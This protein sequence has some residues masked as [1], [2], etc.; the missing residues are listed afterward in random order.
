MLDIKVIRENPDWAKEKLA[1]RGIKPEEID[2]LIS[3]DQKRRVA[4]KS[5]RQSVT[6]FLSK[7]RKQ[8]ATRTTQARQLLTCVK[9][10]KRSRTWMLK[11]LN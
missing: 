1:T 9:L 7:S 5:L 10:V 3:I 11:L 2:E 8:S 6:R 4:L